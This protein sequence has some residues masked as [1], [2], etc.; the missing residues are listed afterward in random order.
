M[1]GIVVQWPGCLPVEE[2]IA[3]SSPVYPAEKL[4]TPLNWKVRV[5]ELWTD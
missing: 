4:L 1:K 5:T 3:G 2:E